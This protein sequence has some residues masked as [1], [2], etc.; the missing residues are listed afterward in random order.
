MTLLIN[1]KAKSFAISDSNMT[2]EVSPPKFMY[3][4]NYPIIILILFVND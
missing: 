3:F 4:P 2:T 1:E